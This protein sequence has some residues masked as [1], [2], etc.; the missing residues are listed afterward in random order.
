ME[1]KRYKYIIMMMCMVLCFTYTFSFYTHAHDETMRYRL[2]L[3]ETTSCR[4]TVYKDSI[5]PELVVCPYG[6]RYFYGAIE[7]SRFWCPKLYQ[8]TNTNDPNGL[9]IFN[10]NFSNLELK[11]YI[12]GQ[13]YIAFAVSLSDQFGITIFPDGTIIQFVDSLG[14][15]STLSYTVDGNVAYV[16]TY[17]TQEYTG[18]FQI[19]V[20]FEFS[21]NA[22]TTA[23]YINI[24][25]LVFERPYLQSDSSDSINSTII[26]QTDRIVN[27]ITGDGS[28]SNA[29]GEAAMDKLDS[30]GSAEKEIMDSLPDKN[31]NFNSQ[32][33]LTGYN[34]GFPIVSTILNSIINHKAVLAV[35]TFVLALG[36]ALFILGRRV[37]K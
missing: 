15:T 16:R 11:G 1:K 6:D 36:L 12:D 23:R 26:S 14:S 21:Q 5:D 33:I 8:Y 18:S 37:G 28:Y 10:F 19:R 35:L 25:S 4:A 22:E 24:S 9:V 34:G 31:F 7:Y 29:K 3:D 27:A 17:V 20:N 13:Y 30:Y 2:I 32:D